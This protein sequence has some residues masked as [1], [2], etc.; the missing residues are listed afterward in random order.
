M[1]SAADHNDGRGRPRKLRDFH[2]LFMACHPSGEGLRIEHATFHIVSLCFILIHMKRNTNA[3]DGSDDRPVIWT[4][5]VSR[6]SRLLR[7]VTP[8]FDD[9]A[10]IENIHL[11]FEQA[12]TTLRGRLRTERCDVLIAAG[13]NGAYLKN[14]IDRP[15]LLVRPDGFDLMQALSKAHR[16][17]SRI[18]LLTHETEVPAFAEFQ[19][20]FGLKVAQRAFVTAEDARTQV[21]ELIAEGCKAI[22][23]TGMAADL[24]ER[25][26][27]SGILLYSA[28]TVRQA[29]EAALDMAT[30]IGRP[31]APSR[32][33]SARSVA[34][35][36]AYSTADLLGESASMHTLRDQI[37]RFAASEHTVL[38]SGETG[39]GKELAAQALHLGSPR[40]KSRFVAVNC[41]AIAESLLESELF[42]YEEG[43]FTGARRGGH[44]GLVQAA[45][46]GTLFLDEIGEMPLNLQTRLLRVLEQREVVKLGSS[47]PTPVD[48]RVL[49]ATHT[50]LGEMVRQGHFRQDLFYR[51]NVL[52]VEIPPL[53][54]RAGDAAQLA[55]HFLD[56]ALSGRKMGWQV[57]ALDAIA[58]Y[59]WPGNVRELR[60]VIDRLAVYCDDQTREISLALLHAVAPELLGSL[61]EAA[62]S[63]ESRPSQDVRQIEA[64]LQRSG[65]DR[66]AAARMLGISRTTLW[67]RLRDASRP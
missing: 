35:Q 48:A 33:S 1:P 67:R 21:R 44:T 11:G 14:R 43:A 24:A 46:S 27:A 45:H 62:W 8:E 19:E 5:S 58:H 42:G 2:G 22:V 64:A 25:A 54:L 6:L 18:G 51:L 61:Q 63:P 41:G 15:V 60:N 7:D 36:A 56:Q 50:D 55:R 20:N 53:R 65:G 31:E 26:G 34:A 38:I 4:V 10:R 39:T 9:R 40:R 37:D 12:V 30:A 16:L 59:S 13:S 32:N 3:A 17:S 66:A 29:F 23:G 49:A 28:D 47:R 57:Q 52:R